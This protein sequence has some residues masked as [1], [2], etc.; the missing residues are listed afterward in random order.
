MDLTLRKDGRKNN[1]RLLIFVGKDMRDREMNHL[2][3]VW[4]L[5][6]A[7]LLNASHVS[8]D[9]AATPSDDLSATTSYGSTDGSIELDLRSDYFATPVTVPSALLKRPVTSFQL[10]VRFSE[11][12]GGTGSITLDDSPVEFNEFGVA[13]RLRAKRSQ[14]RPVTLK[15]IEMDDISGKK[16]QLYELVFADGSL[17]RRLLLVRSL[18]TAHH[19]RLLIRSGEEIPSRISDVR[20]DHEGHAIIK[21]AYMLPMYDATR[22]PKPPLAEPLHPKIHLTS[23][24]FRSPL[25]NR[26]EMRTGSIHV[27]G[28]LGGKGNLEHD[29][30]YVS[31]NAFGDGVGSTL[32][33]FGRVPVTIRRIKSPD[34]DSPAT[35]WRLFAVEPVSGPLNNVLVPGSSP[36]SDAVPGECFLALSPSE[37]GPHRLIIR[38]G[39]KT[40]YVL[41]IHDPDRNRFLE[42][43]SQLSRAT[44]GEQCAIK[45]IKGL[46]G[47]NFRFQIRSDKVTVIVL[48]GEKGTDAVLAEVEGLIHL[49]ALRLSDSQVSDA[50]LAH[51]KD[52]IHLASLNLANTDIG[53]KGLFQLKNLKRLGRVNLNGTAITDAGL[54]NFSEMKNLAEI[55]LMNTQVSDL[56]LAQ[57]RNLTNL[58]DLTLQETKITDEGL[59]LLKANTRLKVLHLSRNSITDAGLAHLTELKNLKSL[60][61]YDTQITEE[62]IRKFRDSLPDCWV[63]H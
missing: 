56:G 34:A 9:H 39:E 52:L 19:H 44:P 22:P 17:K 58:R 29:R 27:S 26:A 3:R 31:F 63:D 41:P 42:L 25:P 62:G 47:Y 33:A 6:A 1:W 18:W 59:K 10:R 55:S 28:T 4:V 61:I 15:R 12:G 50:G 45:A 54:A 60:T 43:Q 7:I 8:D 51:L 35:H 49:T 24:H 23:G 21:F 20:K 30:N 37:T 57:L 16:R 48:G 5:A 11:D 32:M 40:H 36:S 46:L 53:D 13:T 38:D 2:P 14:S